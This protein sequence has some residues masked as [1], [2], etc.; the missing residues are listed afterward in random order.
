MYYTS[1]CGLIYLTSKELH[2][3]LVGRKPSWGGSHKVLQ[4]QFKRAYLIGTKSPLLSSEYMNYIIVLTE[5]Q[6]KVVLQSIHAI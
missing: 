1:P 6:T 5:K 4:L 3:L 2:F